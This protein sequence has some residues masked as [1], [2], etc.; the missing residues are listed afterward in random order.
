[1]TALH[2][3]LLISLAASLCIRISLGYPAMEM[4]ATHSS[5][6]RGRRDRGTLVIAASSISQ[7]SDEERRTRCDELEATDA[8]SR[9]SR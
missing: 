8:L 6:V 2:C 7:S 9:Y 3:L 1:M 5:A 4:M